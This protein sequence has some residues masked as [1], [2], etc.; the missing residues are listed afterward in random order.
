MQGAVLLYN[1]Q[2]A[3]RAIP[4]HQMWEGLKVT[5]CCNEVHEVA[6]SCI[7]VPDVALSC[8]VV[9]EVALLCI[10]VPDVGIL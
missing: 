9:H 7:D 5:L 1:L 10:D 2:T 8:N 3:G 4:P 6:L